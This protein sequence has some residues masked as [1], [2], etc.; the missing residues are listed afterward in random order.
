MRNDLTFLDFEDILQIHNDTNSNEGGGDGIR[1]RGLIESAIAAP[2]TSFG[3]EFLHT[4][5]A[6]MTAALMYALISNHGFVD[7]NKRVG[8]LAAL[9]F[10]D[11]NGAETFPPAQDFEEIVLSVARGDMERDQLADWWRGFR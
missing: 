5:L 11:L 2:K 1:D 8:T 4:D 7:G 3:G 9:V 6:A 10:R